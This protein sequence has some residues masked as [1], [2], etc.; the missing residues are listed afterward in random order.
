MK[1]S[2][3]VGEAADSALPSRRSPDRPAI[4]RELRLCAAVS[5]LAVLSFTGLLLARLDFPARLR[6]VPLAPPPPQN[7]AGFVQESR[8]TVHQEDR[9]IGH[10]A[11]RITARPGGW[12][13]EETILLRIR[14]LGLVQSLRLRTRAELDGDLA[15]HRFRYEADSGGLRFRVEGERQGERLRAALDSGAGLQHVEIGLPP[16]ATLPAAVLP[17]LGARPLRAGER[18][19][20]DWLDPAAL[21]V[22][23]AEAEVLAREEVAG[24][25]GTIPAWRIRLV[26]R[27]VSQTLWLDDA[28]RLLKA[29]GFLGLRLE[30]AAPEAARD[31]ADALEGGDWAELASIP[32]GREIAD[33]AALP[34]LRVRL[35]GLP[36]GSLNVH[37]GRQRLEGEILTIEKEILTESPAALSPAA[38]GALEQA[39]LRPEPFIQS[40]HPRIRETAAEILRGA[41]GEGDLERARRLLR[42]VYEAIEKRPVLAFP[43]ALTTLEHRRGDCNEHAVLL[44]ALARAAGI[45]ARVEVGLVYLRGR[46]SY[47]AW[48]LLHVGRWVTADAAFG[49]LPADAT[50]I[51]LASGSLARQA[52]VAA[53][54]GALEVEILDGEAPERGRR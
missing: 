18:F 4:R 23:P 16:R 22:A 2:P 48:T 42:W 53:A 30:R 44:T 35:T 5:A 40:D 3:L 25:Q 49:Q 45:P 29:R 24:A 50:H 21:A 15:L 52:D 27:G 20:F 10:A 32:A 9:R 31:G 34:R 36:R 43:D 37:G 51:R 54:I 46:F 8:M 33:P 11:S 19:R 14:A 41:E 17:A 47:H 13:L 26:F 6:G 12:E 7:A 39:F 38:R 28:G 1:P